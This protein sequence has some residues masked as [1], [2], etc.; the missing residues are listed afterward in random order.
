MHLAIRACAFIDIGSDPVMR[1]QALAGELHRH[2]M[3]GIC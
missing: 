3:A 1:S 2:G